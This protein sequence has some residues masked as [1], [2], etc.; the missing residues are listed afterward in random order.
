M[1]NAKLQTNLDTDFLK[2]IAV[3][4]MTLD[5]VGTAFFP[6]IRYFAGSDG[7]PF[8]SSATV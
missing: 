4:A 3:I 7:W 6:S 5:H 1:N 2:L 8:P